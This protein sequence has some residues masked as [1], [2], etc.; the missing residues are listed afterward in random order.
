MLT[1][2]QNDT[3]GSAGNGLEGDSQIVVSPDGNNVYVLGRSDNAIVVF[4][5]NATTGWST[6]RQNQTV[7]TD[8]GL[9]EPRD[10]VISPTGTHVYVI[11]GTGNTITRYLRTTSGPN[12]GNLTRLVPSTTGGGPRDRH[13]PSRQ[14]CLHNQRVQPGDLEPQRIHR[15]AHARW[16]SIFQRPSGQRR[17]NCRCAHQRHRPL[18][19]Q[20]RRVLYTMSSGDESIG[21]YKRNISSGSLQ[22]VE[23]V[24]RDWPTARA[25]SSMA[26]MAANRS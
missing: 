21:V 11:S 2:G 15:W 6:F 5:R 9:T 18:D 22:F 10:L 25:R 8:T 14:L 4:D 19:Q 17:W 3:N 20:R 26:S 24:A 16:N 1:S 7:A 23:E 13:R 12:T